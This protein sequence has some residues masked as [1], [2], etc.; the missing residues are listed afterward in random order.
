MYINLPI[1][2]LKTPWVKHRFNKI[3]RLYFTMVIKVVHGIQTWLKI[4]NI[5]CTLI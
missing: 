4:R 2:D 5:T 1:S 3:C